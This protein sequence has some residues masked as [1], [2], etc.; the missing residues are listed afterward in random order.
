MAFLFDAKLRLP[1]VSSLH[2][3]GDQ[4]DKTTAPKQQQQHW[5]RFSDQMR[6]QRNDGIETRL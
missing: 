5:P 3:A 6:M 2:S 1:E 4:Q